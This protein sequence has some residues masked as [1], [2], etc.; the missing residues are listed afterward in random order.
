MP[1][2]FDEET[3]RIIQQMQLAEQNL[4]NL[5]LQKQTFQLESSETE[6][7]LD[8]L[9]EAKG[10]VYKIVGGIMLKASKQQL[11]KELKRK[12]E[13]LELR[14][15]AIEKQERALQDQLAKTREEVMKKISA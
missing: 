7:A 11:E 2:K 9:K 15:K 10:D 8:E 12:H 14:I 13:L 5:L 1:E 4:Q 6:A 3:T